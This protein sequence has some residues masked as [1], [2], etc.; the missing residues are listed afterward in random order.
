MDPNAE[1]KQELSAPNTFSP[2]L[3]VHLKA[4]S[5]GDELRDEAIIHS[6]EVPESKSSRYFPLKRSLVSFTAF[7]GWFGLFE[8]VQEAAVCWEKVIQA[9]L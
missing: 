1:L 9:V 7:K 8:G 6:K 3:S 5:C 2:R 4:V